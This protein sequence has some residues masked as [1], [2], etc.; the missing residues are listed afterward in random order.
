MAEFRLED[1]RGTDLYSDGDVEEKILELA[2]TG[3]LGDDTENPDYPVL[4]HLSHVRENIL[5]WYPFREDAS[6]LEIGSGCGALTRLLCERLEQVVSVELSRRRAEVNFARNEELPN[7]E[8][9]VGNLNDMTFPEGFDYVILNGVFEYAKGFTE[10]ERPYETFLKKVRSFLKPGGVILVA[11]ENRLGLKYFAG[12]PEDHTDGYYEGVR[13]YENDP[14]VRTFSRAEWETLMS[15][16]GL[17]HWNF[18]YPYPDYKFPNEIFTDESLAMQRYGNP[19]WNF[20]KYRFALFREGE[21][22]GALQSEGVLAHFA[23]SFLIEMSTEPLCSKWEIVYAKLSTDRAPGFRIATL[24]AELHEEGKVGDRIVVKIPMTPEAKDHI[25]NMLEQQSD[26]GVWYVLEGMETN[27]SIVYPYLQ[28]ESL[29]QQAGAA[30][31]AGDIEKI[32]ELLG[33]AARLCGYRTDDEVKKTDSD[34]AWGRTIAAET[35]KDS[36]DET[37]ADTGKTVCA[38]EL[39][40]KEEPAEN[41]DAEGMKAEEE[42]AKDRVAE[43]MKAEE[44]PAE[45]ENAKESNA[46]EEPAKDD[47]AGKMR[48]EEAVSE[49]YAAE[50]KTAGENNIVS[51]NVMADLY[52]HVKGSGIGPEELAQFEK[53]FGSRDIPLDADCIAPANIDLILDNLFE[54]DGRYC[55]IDCEWIFPFPVPAAFVLWRVVNELYS[56]YP[57]LEQKCPRQSVLDSYEITSELSSRFHRWATYFAEHYVGANRLQKSSIPEIG[58]SLETFRQ[59]LQ[60]CRDILASQL[61]VDTGAGFHEEQKLVQSTAL[62]DGHFLQTFDLEGFENIQALRFD[63]V[64]GMPCICKIDR[65]ATNVRLTAANAA[66]RSEKEAE[67]EDVFLTADPVYRIEDRTDEKTIVIAGEIKMLSM[68]EVLEQVNGLLPNTGTWKGKK[69]GLFRKQ[70]QRKGE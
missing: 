61:F 24:I 51:E 43:G 19:T 53:V 36:P 68:K 25:K 39:K 9:R 14:P 44:E 27:G 49:E 2:K 65:T 23:N 58:V 64:E 31:K 48:H 13:G 52:R 40:V 38:A 55:A 35:E 46:E 33:V 70:K 57:L 47:S 6:G 5:N 22:A 12:A 60:P 42:S 10:G 30:W 63:P 8:I 17:A 45:D 28:E 56:K 41:K 29:G 37:D 16:C 32:K 66:V 21:L 15:E 34:G 1:Y 54:H 7:L 59:K 62:V 18:Y 4:Y 69:H 67:E 26:F 11:I 3:G 20:T 50:R